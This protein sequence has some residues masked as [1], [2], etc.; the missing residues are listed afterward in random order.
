M[1]VSHVAPEDHSPVRP[2]WNCSCGDRR[3]P[4]PRA[5]ELLLLTTDRLSLAMY[6]ADWMTD[7]ARDLPDVTPAELF[8]RFMRWT[9]S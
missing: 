8:E 1:A 2:E 6:A 3:W 5:R 4:C 7:A 9:R